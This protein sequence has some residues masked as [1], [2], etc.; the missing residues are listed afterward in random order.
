MSQ[1]KYKETLVKG[2]QLYVAF[3]VR[4]FVPIRAKLSIRE[5]G[6]RNG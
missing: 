6:D 3:K 1:M 5:K 2:P 4:K